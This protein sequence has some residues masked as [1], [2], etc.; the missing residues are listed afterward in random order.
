MIGNATMP[1]Q[2]VEREKEAQLAS[3]KA[4]DEEMTFGRAASVARRTCSARIPM[5]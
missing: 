5:G 1:A 4:E 2:A 3:I